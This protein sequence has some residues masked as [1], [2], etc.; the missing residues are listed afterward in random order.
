MRRHFLRAFFLLLYLVN[1]SYAET[2]VYDGNNIAPFKGRTKEDVTAKFLEAMSK[3]GSYRSTY[4]ET[5]YKVK[6]STQYPY[7]AGELTQ[8]THN[9]MTAMSDF[10]RWL[11]GV[12]PLEG[13]SVHSDSLQ[14]QALD[15][16][17]EFAH[18]ISQDSKPDDM[19]QELWDIGF[20]SDHNSLN[21]GQTPQNAISSWLNEGYL[22]YR[23]IWDTGGN[24]YTVGHRLT[25]I[26]GYTS[27][28][29]FGVCG[30]VDIAKITGYKNSF[31]ASFAAFPPPG[32]MPRRK[33]KA[34]SS[35]WNVELNQN[36]ITAPDADKVTVNVTDMSS[37][38]SYTCTKANGKISPGSGRRCIIFSQ[39][40]SHDDE[41]YYAH[42]FRV[43]VTG[44]IDVATGNDAEITYTVSFMELPPEALTSSPLT[45]TMGNSFPTF[46]HVEG[47]RPMTCEVTEGSMPEGMSINDAA[48][49]KRHVV[50]GGSAKEY[51]VID[52]TPQ[53]KGEYMFTVKY[54]NAYGTDETPYVI[55]VENVKPSITSEI[56]TTLSVDVP[57]NPYPLNAKGSLP[58]TW[59]IESGNLPDG[60]SF[61]DE[62]RFSGIPSREGTF[63]FT[64]KAENSA[65]YDTKTF[66]VRT[67][68][69]KPVIKTE[70][71]SKP[72]KV[73][74]NTSISYRIYAEG[75]G[76]ITWTLVSGTL[77]D[78]I[79]LSNEGILSGRAMKEGTFTF[80]VRAE[81]E[82]GYD[83]RTYTMT[84]E[85][86]KP[87]ISG[88]TLRSAVAG[89]QYEGYL[90]A[91]GTKPIS[92]R[93][94]GGKLPGGLALSYDDETGIISGVP[95]EAGRY[96]F[97]VTAENSTGS[98]SKE[99]TL[100]VVSGNGT[101]ENP[102]P[103]YT[104]VTAD[105]I[106]ALMG[107]D[108]AT[109]FTEITART[110]SGSY[111]DNVAAVLGDIEIP[112][113]G[114]YLIQ[115]IALRFRIP[116]GSYLTWHNS[117]GSFPSAFYGAANSD[118]VFFDDYGN[119][120]TMPTASDLYHVS[121]AVYLRYDDPY[122]DPYPENEEPPRENSDSSGGGGCNSIT[123]LTTILT[124]PLI[125]RR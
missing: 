37:G 76:P 106:R 64:I 68:R 28:L 56:D 117:G 58:I 125:R 11:C 7:N 101:I 118:C 47:S 49:D 41:G 50:I 80:T 73:N 109:P 36:I 113:T 30:G 107:R 123:I 120:I 71:F 124:L 53:R 60:L 75:S 20:Q 105:R 6:P 44:L 115:N 97:T 74:S 24:R 104:P 77:P 92:W 86:E 91:S 13:V 72:L 66:T 9:T 62:G 108:N 111:D 121:A 103:V 122:Y 39:P 54:T 22:L 4:R 67:V 15:R 83:T 14:H 85:A 51:A 55:I 2:V 114:I 59:S 46:V 25:I 16:N 119:E 48:D 12:K 57:Y 42:D 79:T 45:V 3:R 95:T 70:N 27:S 69:T 93:L 33:L 8:D 78:G 102:V 38:N 116:A 84:A 35:A 100:D 34:Y 81:N 29:L 10:Y 32:L 19:P 63:T 112:S 87:K 31:E 18:Y 82:K 43:N 21:L 89:R 98:D 96:T 23:G 90:Y 88:L 110:I 94:T 40:S 52:G 99:Y 1:A 61:S 26:S 65:G 17:F 5:W